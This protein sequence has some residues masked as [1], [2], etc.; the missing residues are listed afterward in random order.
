MIFTETGKK[1]IIEFEGTDTGI[2]MKV[3][4]NYF[5]LCKSILQLTHKDD[6]H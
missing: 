2:Q 1:L 5:Y 3:A 4:Y 6:K